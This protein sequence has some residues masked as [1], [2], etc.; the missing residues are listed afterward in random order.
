MEGQLERVL[1]ILELKERT[2]DELEVLSYYLQRFEEIK[3]FFRS[4][5]HVVI[6][7]LCR[8]FGLAQYKKNEIVHTQGTAPLIYYLVLKGSVGLY[9]EG[10]LLGKIST[11]KAIGEREIIKDAVYAHSGIGYAPVTFVLTLSRHNFTYTLGDVISSENSKKLQYLRM[12]LPN[13]SRLSQNL[14][15]RLLQGLRLENYSKGEVI[16]RK[17]AISDSLLLIA[18]GECVLVSNSGYTSKEIV[19]VGKGSTYAE[20]CILNDTPTDFS[21][22]SKRES[23]V[24]FIKKS[25]VISIFPDSI[26]KLLRNNLEVK[27]IQRSQVIDFSPRSVV[28]EN[29]FPLASQYARRKLSEIVSRSSKLSPSRLLNHQ[30]NVNGNFKNQLL[31]MRDSSPKRV[32][33]PTL[34]RKNRSIHDYDK[35]SLTLT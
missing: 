5:N 14:Q 35:L 32:F 26:I 28:E 17:G 9:N 4:L 7:S 30:K 6:S 24:A 31:F 12:L 8:E 29:S 19:R 10:K 2:F 27:K 22:I 20:E 21:L 34:R 18:E 25:D 16:L 1:A 33:I 11:G 3:R 23:T 15:E 13:F